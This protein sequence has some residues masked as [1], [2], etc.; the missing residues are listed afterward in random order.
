MKPLGAKVQGRSGVGATPADERRRAVTHLRVDVDGDGQRLD[1]HLVRVLKGVPRAWI[2]R[3]IRTGEVR[4]NGHRV[5]V[6]AR[7]SPGD[8]IRVPPV[9]RPDRGPAAGA[10]G[11]AASRPLEDCTV[12]QEDP[13]WLVLDKPAGLAVHGG[14]GVA[15]G[16]IERLRASRPEDRFLELAHRLDR[17][18]SGLIVVARSRPALL[19]LHRQFVGGGPAKHYRALVAGR[20]S[21]ARALL[22]FPLERVSAPDGDRRVRVVAGAAPAATEVTLLEVR[23][24]DPG[25]GQPAWFSLLDCRLLTGRT[26]QIRVH[27]SHAGFPIIG[28]PKYG[29]FALN[30]LLQKQGF[31]RMFL[32]AFSISLSHPIDGRRCRFEAPLPAIFERLGSSPT[33]QPAAAV[34]A[35]A[36]RP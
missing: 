11:G 24:G 21:R 26:H 27:L 25:R 33:G 28:D 9:R 12:V 10:G 17:E 22:Q 31:N 6:H 15:A 8:D 1:N 16:L 13:A 30:K 35:E 14:S 32:H 2:W 19:S 29:D 36:T 4:L 18:T 7:L 23:P 34:A 20:W 3:S 5:A